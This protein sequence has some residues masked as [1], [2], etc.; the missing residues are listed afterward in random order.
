MEQSRA[1]EYGSR[2]ASPDFLKPRN[3]YKYYETLETSSA[4]IVVTDFFLK[5]AI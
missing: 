3:I 4:R 5:V 1:M 2:K